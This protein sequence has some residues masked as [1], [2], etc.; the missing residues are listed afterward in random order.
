MKNECV[1]N[2]NIAN[3][4]LDYIKNNTSE[5][6][7]ILDSLKIITE[8]DEDDECGFGYLPDE[9]IICISEEI[10]N[11]TQ[12]KF[13]IDY[14]NEV[15][16]LNLKNIP[17]TRSIHA[18]LHEL[19]HALDLGSLTKEQYYERLE[20][21]RDYDFEIKI[22]T[23]IIVQ[24][25]VNVAEA[26]QECIEDVQEYKITMDEYLVNMDKLTK[27]Y[28]ELRDKQK[29]ADRDYRLNPSERIADEGAAKFFRLLKPIMPQLFEEQEH[30]ITRK[31]EA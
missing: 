21:Y 31:R 24:E 28:N 18:F 17:L 5:D 7:V 3:A 29:Q 26:I 2:M 15:F 9:H 6:S 27:D 30:L 4:L 16:D 25:I 20:S 19:S 10:L 22:R 12:D 11:S 14:T 23:H 1:F 13:I 8:Y